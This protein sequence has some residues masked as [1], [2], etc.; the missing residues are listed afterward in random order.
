[1]KES[2]TSVSNQFWIPGLPYT[3]AG[4]AV[5]IHLIYFS[6]LFSHVLKQVSIYFSSF[7]ECC[8]SRNVLWTWKNFT[9]LFYQRVGGSRQWMSSH[10]CP[11]FSFKIRESLEYSIRGPLRHL[12][13]VHTS[14]YWVINSCY[15]THILSPHSFVR[16]SCDLGHYINPTG[17]A[18]CPFLVAV[19]VAQHRPRCLAAPAEKRAPTGLFPWWWEPLHSAR[20]AGSGRGPPSCSHLH[21]LP[22]PEASP[23]LPLLPPSLLPSSF[24]FPQVMIWPVN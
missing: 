9:W 3:F 1:M 15:D 4:G 21:S 11:N 7:G 16:A 14:M 24:K 12:G 22:F 23:S 13:C 8:K 6:L 20:S 2:I 18:L 17:P 19:I 5:W 10:F